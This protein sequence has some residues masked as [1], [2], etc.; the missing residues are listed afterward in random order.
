MW[1]QRVSPARKDSC[2]TICFGSRSEPFS[3]KVILNIAV[4]LPIQILVRRRSTLSEKAPGRRRTRGDAGDSM[5]IIDIKAAKI[6]LKYVGL[7]GNV[8]FKAQKPNFSV[9]IHGK[10]GLVLSPA[11]TNILLTL[12]RE[13]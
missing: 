4:F 8:F 6:Q 3:C 1:Q 9:K 5:K 2:P 7:E 10:R 12:K 11:V 13:E